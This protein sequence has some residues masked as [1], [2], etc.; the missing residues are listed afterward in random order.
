[1]E[2]LLSRLNYVI[3]LSFCSFAI[4]S[5]ASADDEAKLQTLSVTGEILPGRSGSLEADAAFNHL[6]ALG[7]LLYQD[8]ALKD[9]ARDLGVPQLLTEYRSSPEARIVQCCK[10]I[11]AALR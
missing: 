2:D 9:I 3:F 1:M 7:T 8:S 11:E 5:T 4:L 10:E 6:L